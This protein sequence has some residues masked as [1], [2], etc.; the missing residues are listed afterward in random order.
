MTLPSL[1]KAE[2]LIKTSKAEMLIK[3][4]RSPKKV[5]SPQYFPLIWLEFAKRKTF[6]VVRCMKLGMNGLVGAFQV[7]Q[8]LFNLVGFTGECTQ[9]RTSGFANWNERERDT[10]ECK[11]QKY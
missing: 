6:H 3:T 9:G 4:C 2:M 8:M 5:I 10:I 7:E 11:Q 1:S